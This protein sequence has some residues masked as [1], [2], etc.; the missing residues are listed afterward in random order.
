MA[1]TC[2]LF[3]TT[4]R[5]S[6]STTLLIGAINRPS[7][8][9]LSAID[10]VNVKP[11]VLRP[12]EWSTTRA[13]AAT[14]AATTTTLSKIRLIEVII[15]FRLNPS[16]TVLEP[17]ASERTGKT[18]ELWGPKLQKDETFYVQWQCLEYADKYFLL[19]SCSKLFRC[20]FTNRETTKNFRSSSSWFRKS[21]FSSTLSTKPIRDAVTEYVKRK[22]VTAMDVVY[23][24]KPRAAPFTDSAANSFSQSCRQFLH[25]TIDSFPIVHSIIFLDSLSYMKT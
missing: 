7:R 1:T 15:A 16:V 24:L 3:S 25:L 13:T 6:P 14:T 5:W 4:P 23:A 10:A 22:T 2:S 18:I 11:V 12:P 8:I 19:L 21:T 20:Q 9:V 17:N